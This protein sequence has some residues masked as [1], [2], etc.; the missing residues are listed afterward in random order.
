MSRYWLHRISHFQETSRPLLEKGFLTIGFSDFSNP[1]FLAPEEFLRYERSNFDAKFQELWDCVPRSRYFLWRFLHEM[2]KDDFVLVP[3]YRTYSVYEIEGCAKPIGEIPISD[4]RTSTGDIV[5]KRE[6]LLYA[7][8]QLIDLGFFRRVKLHRIG[9]EDGPEAKDINRYEYADNALTR[10]LKFFGTTLDISDLENSIRRS[11][12]RYRDQ[13]PLNLHSRIVE[14]TTQKILGLICTELTDSKFESLI[15][16]YFR[17]IGA[18]EI[19]IPPKN[20]SDKAGDADVIATFEPIKTIIYVQAKLHKKGSKTDEWAVEQIREYVDYKDTEDDGYSKVSWVVSTCD[21]FTECCQNMANSHRV[22]L[23]NG[24]E[25][26]RMLIHA[27]IEGLD[28]AFD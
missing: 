7:Q 12:A 25:F 10:R 1:E 16:W 6:G 15:K 27:G 3:G 21:C 18:S 20:E 2:S 26:A 24:Q 9:G 8:G 22:T 5:E 4:L 23:I 13:K 11:L 19:Y 14:E 28:T 17:R